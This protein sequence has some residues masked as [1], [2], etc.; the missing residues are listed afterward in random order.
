[1]FSRTGSGVYRWLGLGAGVAVT[2]S[3]AAPWTAPLVLSL[4]VAGFLSASLMRTENQ[5]LVWEP[6]A[7]TLLGVCY[8]NWL[9]GY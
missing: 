3:F 6:C 2:A 8:V 1:M 5:G 7:L 4:T 9:L